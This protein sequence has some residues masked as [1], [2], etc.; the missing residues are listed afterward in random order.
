MR[1][2]NPL[3]ANPVGDGESDDEGG[4]G[5]NCEHVAQQT[6]EKALAAKNANR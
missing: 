1:I 6:Q 3:D 2:A 4:V 5:E